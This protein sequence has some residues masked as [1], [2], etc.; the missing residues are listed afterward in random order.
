MTIML[1]RMEKHYTHSN[2]VPSLE[3]RGLILFYFSY[4]LWKGITVSEQQQQQIPS[5]Q[6]AS[7]PKQPQ[8][9]Q[10]RRSRKKVTKPSRRKTKAAVG[11]SQSL[12]QRLLQTV[13]PVLPKV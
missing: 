10:K 11:T 12:A 7:S 4:G 9:R 6:A 8:V 3:T 1:I 13:Q 2:S 5:H